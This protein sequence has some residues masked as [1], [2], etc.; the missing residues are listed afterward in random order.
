MQLLFSSGAMLEDGSIWQVK[1]DLSLQ[2]TS[3][4]S[5][6]AIA[7]MIA[8]APSEVDVRPQLLTLSP[9]GTNLEREAKTYEGGWWRLPRGEASTWS[10]G[11]GNILAMPS[12]IIFRSETTERSIPGTRHFLVGLD[13]K[14]LLLSLEHAAEEQG[15]PFD[16]ARAQEEL[17]QLTIAGDVWVDD[18][19]LLMRRLQWVVQRQ[20]QRRSEMRVTV[21]FSD[22]DD[23]PRL[24]FPADVLSLPAPF[25]D[26]LRRGVLSSSPLSLSSLSASSGSLLLP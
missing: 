11:P 3:G 2:Q 17:R 22:H 12:A 15:H 16:A 1:A 18:H 13:E 9:D 20:D 10:F 14:T 19:S 26:K 23:V 24:E 6:H 5:F 21:D 7:D 25:L 4:A 8:A